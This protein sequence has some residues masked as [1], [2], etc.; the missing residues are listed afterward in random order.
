MMKKPLKRRKIKYAVSRKI[1]GLVFALPWLLGFIIFFLAPLKDTILYSFNSV[2]VAPSGG[3]QFSFTG[4]KNYIDLFTIEVSTKSQPLT[5]VFVDENIAVFTGLPLITLFSLFLA[6]L[7]NAKFPGRGLVR[8]IFFLPIV[9]GLQLITDWTENSVGRGMIEGVTGTLH[10]S[11]STMRLLL[12]YTFLPR[13]VVLFLTGAMANI[14][15]LFTRTGVQTMIFLAGLQSISPSHYEV[16][17][18]EGANAYEIFWKITIPSI[19]DVT[20]FVI[21]YTLIDLFRGSSIAEEVY[22]FAFAKS[23]I[24]VGSALSVVYMVNVFAALG[25]VWAF[26]RG[27]KI[28][29]NK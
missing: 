26:M 7:A 3:I 20:V 4:M 2:D 23:K 9:L 25:V 24:G 15:T 29:D 14:F 28:I 17:K 6:I 27:A 5:R 10:T 16:A 8:V 12:T 18:I 22:N 19:A 21:I 13:S 1:N 11:S